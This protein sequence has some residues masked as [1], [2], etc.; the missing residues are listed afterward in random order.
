MARITTPIQASLNTAT[1]E[2][3]VNTPEAVTFWRNSQ[4]PF[5]G[6]LRNE[7]HLKF[8]TGAGGLLIVLIIMKNGK[9]EKAPEN[10]VIPYGI[11][12]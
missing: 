10:H 11:K 1:W 6:A 8:E 2:G 4:V 5:R 12:N 3:A 9:M 7:G